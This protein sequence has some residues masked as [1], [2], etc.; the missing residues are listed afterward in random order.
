M[1]GVLVLW[2]RSWGVEARADMGVDVAVRRCPC[3]H[4]CL[5]LFLL[6]CLR[7]ESFGPRSSYVSYFVIQ[8]K[9]GYAVLALD[10][11]QSCALL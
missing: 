1:C 5:C 6:V 11:H 4:S 2:S 9:S 7:R 3:L 10:R 8:V